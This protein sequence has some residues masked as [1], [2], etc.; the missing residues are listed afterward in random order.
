MEDMEYYGDI[1]LGYGL[2][3][4]QIINV[5]ALSNDE[6]GLKCNCLCPNCKT[7]LLAKL[8]SKNR[9]HFAHVNA[10]CDIKIANQ[11]ALHILAKEIIEKYKQ[12]TFPALTVDFEETDCPDLIYDYDMSHILPESLEY[13]KAVK[14]KCDE[15]VLE[16]MVSGI[17][18]D[19]MI[20]TNNKKCMIE[21]AVTHFIDNEKME[22][23]KE[24]ALPV[25]EID[26]SHLQSKNLSYNEL[27]KILID[28][29]KYKRWIY[30]P[31][32]LEAIKWAKDEYEKRLDLAEAEEEK[33]IK[34]LEVYL[35]QKRLKKQQREDKMSY[36]LIPENYKNKLGTLRNDK[37]FADFY[38]QTMICK[39]AK[40]IPFYMD[41]PVFGEMIF[42]CDRRI[43]QCAIFEKFIYNRKSGNSTIN[44]N[45]IEAWSVSFQDNFQIDW[46]LMGSIN[47]ES[48]RGYKK[49]NLLYHCINTYLKYL[50][51]LGFVEK[52][53]I[54][55]KKVLCVKSI[56]PPENENM[57]M[58]LE[59][60]GEIDTNSVDIDQI[61]DM[62]LKKKIHLLE[63][64]EMIKQ[65]IEAEKLKKQQYKE[66]YESSYQEVLLKFNEPDM[67]IIRDSN[68]GR[69]FKCSKCNQILRDEQMAYTQYTS[70]LCK[71]CSREK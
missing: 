62:V 1:K 20:L 11:T 57:K 6:K 60:L 7:Q 48:N 17:I 21:I 41:I 63:Y 5:N 12:F 49:I 18:P 8:G 33:L 35:E 34:E 65:K 45:K 61:I 27:K 22:K 36:L 24:I 2:R 14:V 51:F 9:W 52:T 66:E 39:L 13:I 67:E 46:S 29:T 15:V 44:I 3:D 55:T 37:L 4:G 23:I 47:Y 31:K 25:V 38:Q 64:N 56:F 19:V 10:E 68:G 50:A 30:N 53:Y 69:W 70:G 54:D 40:T 71:N 32:K 43:W 28:G 16:K 59:T 26:L 58:L 42:D